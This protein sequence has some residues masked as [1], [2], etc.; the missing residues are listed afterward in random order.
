MRVDGLQSIRTEH[1]VLRPLTRK[2]AAAM[3]RYRADPEVARYQTW[4]ARSLAEIEAFIERNAECADLAPGTWY[5]IAIAEAA[6]ALIG[7]IG[8]H[9]IEDERQIELGVTLAPAAQRRGLATEALTALLDWAFCDLRAHRVF[10][11]VDPRNDRSIALMHRLHFRQ[12]AHFRE[13]LCIDGAWVD[14]MVFAM[15]R[16]DWQHGSADGRETRA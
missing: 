4:K 1:L 10:A 12:E 5:Q 6:D 2:D 14:D 3:F 9:V 8:I 15:L 13:S 11:A 16:H 7:D